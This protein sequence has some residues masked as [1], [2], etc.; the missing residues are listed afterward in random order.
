MIGVGVGG[1]GGGGGWSGV[2]C[3]GT[4]SSRACIIKITLC[5]HKLKEIFYLK[6]HSTHFNYGYVASDI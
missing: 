3:D 1:G 4:G 5:S 2:G 6:T